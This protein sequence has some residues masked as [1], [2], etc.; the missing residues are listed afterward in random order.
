MGVTEDV[1]REYP[2]VVFEGLDHDMT[3]ASYGASIP[4]QRALSPSSDVLL[5]FQMNGEELPRDH[6]FP[7][8]VIVPGVVGARSVK[9]RWDCA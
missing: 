7:L 2:H 5:A 3:G 8:R 1:A 4:L 6:G 9:V